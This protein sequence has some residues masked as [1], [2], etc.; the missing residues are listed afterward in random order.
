M[1]KLLSRVE[2]VF[3]IAERGCVVCPGILRNSESRLKIGDKLWLERPDGSEVST[4]VRGIEMGGPINSPGIPILL[5]A[6]ITKHEVPVGTNMTVEFT[7]T[8][9]FTLL[10][11]ATADRL[12]LDR[13][14]ERDEKGYLHFGWSG[15]SKFIAT[16]ND[17]HEVPIEF[18]DYLMEGFVSYHMQTIIDG[19]TLTVIVALH[20]TNRDQYLRSH[21]TFHLRE[22]G[23]TLGE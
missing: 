9:T 16:T 21:V 13:I 8:E 17:I 22:A 14:F 3:Q 2:D 23:L 19:E 6:E 7:P 11:K 4:I 18:T 15:K 20:G 10:A 12:D 1:R 5:G